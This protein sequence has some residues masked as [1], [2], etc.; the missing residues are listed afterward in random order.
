MLSQFICPD[1]VKINISDCLSQCRIPH[2]FPCGRCLSTRFLYILSKTRPWNGIPT[3]TQLISGSREEFLKLNTDYAVSPQN[4]VFALFGSIFHSST[5]LASTALPGLSETRF[6]D[7]TN[8]YSGQFDFYD[9][10][11]QILYDTKTFGSFKAAQ[12]LGISKIKEPAIDPFS[13]EFLKTKSGKTKFSSRFVQ[14][15]RH[16]RDFTLQLNAY[17]I[18]L[19]HRGFP[20]K[21]MR[22]EIFVRDGGTWIANDRGIHQNA[23]LLNVNR[24][25][26]HR[27]Q[28]FMLAKARCLIDAIN[29]NKMPPPCRPIETWG[30]VKC[31][32]FCPVRDSCNHY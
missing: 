2:S 19:E 9:P 12:V 18:M 22:L 26:D 20:V 4:R 13:G 27:L 5:D 29:Q 8:T 3:V 6:T 11:E 7:P 1:G 32:L 16:L 23:I 15:V 28:S 31:R 24:V 10:V 17:R 25:S 30:G 21:H 14:G